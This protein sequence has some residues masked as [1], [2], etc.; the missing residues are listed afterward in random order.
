M[1]FLNRRKPPPR[2]RVLGIKPQRMKYIILSIVVLVFSSCATYLEDVK[3]RF[4][5]MENRYQ[6]T[7]G[8]FKRAG[9]DIEPEQEYY[10]GRGIAAVLLKTYPPYTK[11][12]P[13]TAYLNYICFTIAINSSYPDV[14]N[15]YHVA[16][17]DS[18]EINAFATPGGHIFITLGL[19]E[20]TRSEDELAAVIAHE[21][22][23]IQLQHGIKAIKTNRKTN[24]ILTATSNYLEYISQETS[25]ADMV[26]DFNEVVDEGV[27]ALVNNGYSQSQE[28]EAD[29]M[30]L[31]LMASAG[32]NPSSFINMLQV[33]DREQSSHPGGFNKTHPQP[34]DRL[35][36][37]KRHLSLY[38]STSDT[39]SFRERRYSKIRPF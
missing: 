16:L 12:K 31:S 7:K 35:S 3:S 23:H 19:L 36:R 8:A 11:N 38:K 14:Y 27:N 26:R 15:G 30:A 28:F 32:Y 22:A 25:L 37:A 6:E 39:R 34:S 4:A 18:N 13:L 9:E 29:E 20:C 2:K 1:V 5:D 24:A 17:L 33:L 21:I 10:I